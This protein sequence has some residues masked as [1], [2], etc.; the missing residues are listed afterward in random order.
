[1]RHAKIEVTGWDVRFA[2]TVYN[3]SDTVEKWNLDPVDDP[4]G[5]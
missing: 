5:F 3:R 4:I 2:I 1:M